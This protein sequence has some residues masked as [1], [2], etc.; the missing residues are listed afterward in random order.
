MTMV[1]RRII[2]TLEDVWYRASDKRTVRIQ[3]SRS[4]DAVGRDTP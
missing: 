1:A 3:Y 2:R 4:T